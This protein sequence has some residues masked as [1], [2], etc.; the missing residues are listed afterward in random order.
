MLRSAAAALRPIRGPVI[1]RRPSIFASR[2]VRQDSSIHSEDDDARELLMAIVAADSPGALHDLRR[3]HG[4]SSMASAH[5]V[6]ALLQLAQLRGMQQDP[7]AAA[8]VVEVGC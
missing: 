7:M 8:G 5:L 2:V 3:R 4:G 6:A 1:I